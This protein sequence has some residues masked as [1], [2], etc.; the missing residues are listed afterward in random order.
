MTI[1]STGRV[2]VGVLLI[3]LIFFVFGLTGTVPR[4]LD[5]GSRAY[6]HEDP[7][8][9]GPLR[10]DPRQTSPALS[11]EALRRGRYQS[12]Q[13]N[14]DPNGNNILG[15]AANEPTLA[16]DPTNP[17]RMVI[18]WRQFDTIASN[19]R[20]AGWAYS[21][22]GG[23]TWTFP[24]V[25]VPDEFRTDPVLDVDG[26]GNF[27]Y[28]SLYGGPLDTCHV[29][30]SLD[31]GVSWSDPVYAYGGDKNWLVVDRSASMGRGNVY[32][33]WQRF[34]NCCGDLTFTRSVDGGASFSYPVHIPSSPSFGT[35][36]VGPDGAVY[37]AGIEAINSQNYYQFVV[38][39][40]TDAKDPNAV[41]TFVTTDVDLGGPMRINTGSGPNP[42]GLLS[43]VWVA[44][45]HS[46]GPLNGYVYVLCCT[47]PYGSDPLDV[48]L[49]R[50]TDGGQTWSAPIRVN[51][52]PPGSRRWQWFGTLSVAPDSRL[53]VVWN[54]TRNSNNHRISELF[55]SY[56]TDGGLS[57]TPNE[58]LTPPFDSYLGWPDQNKL[59]D[60]YHMISD[61]LGA[62]LAYAATFNGE[63]DVYYLRIR[64]FDCNNNDVHDSEDIAAGTSVDCNGNG[65]PDECE[66][67]CND[68]NVVDD[69]DV[70]PNDPDGDGWVSPDCNENDVPD[71][72]EPGGN[73]NCNNNDAPDLCDIY[74][75]TSADCNGNYV[76]DECDIAEATSA[77]CNANDVPDECDISAGTSRDCN[78]NGVPD[79]CDIADCDGSL[80]CADCQPNGVLDTCEPTPMRDNCCDAL[81]V[82]PGTAHYGTTSGAS[83][84]G[85]S[86]CGAS[87]G[88]PDV[89]YYYKP[90][91]Y[92]G[93]TISL[94]GSS[95]DTVLSV[96]GGCPG[97]ESNELVCNDDYC[98]QQS[99]VVLSIN[100]SSAGYWIRVSGK[101]GATG[102]FVMNLSGPACAVGPE[103][104]NNGIPDECEPD[105]NRN[106]IPDDCDLDPNDPDDDGLVSLDSNG[107]NFPDE[108]ERPGDLDCD[109]TVSESDID[110]FVLA[111]VDP[112]TY[113]TT[114]PDCHPINADCNLDGKVNSLD[115]DAFVELLSER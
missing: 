41:P 2:T 38:A 16:L 48:H 32:A 40:S 78:G 15:D 111:L 51:D 100:P 101:N 87:A 35:L 84:D 62:H 107:N 85:S 58:P 50:S 4:P 47:D 55:Y 27:Y 79:L 94:C 1:N 90:D 109:G 95:Y 20:Q 108:C 10:L 112:E 106:G 60:Y 21:H 7:P 104:N 52:D 25:L 34:Y 18:G 19:F 115:I 114:N 49:I 73:E 29:F 63:Q 42:N 110:L 31:G 81:G 46:V 70:D 92:G 91:S 11:P 54:D 102:R 6:R 5:E 3:G 9:S 80:W 28:H 26:D 86:G 12:V 53:D 23:Q 83:N 65:V 44:V 17:S 56:S 89:W 14:T 61:E 64:T 88:T 72:C 30:K 59:G 33:I 13:V 82:C 68:N 37:A 77:D 67:D 113:Q 57:W 74:S 39:K 105:C 96:H 76:P 71:E 8:T 24:G 75:G 66:P 93:L 43:Q 69:C 97:T 99:R 103:C 22:D 45:D 36:A 98:G